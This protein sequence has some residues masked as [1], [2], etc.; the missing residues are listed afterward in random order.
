MSIYLLCM[1]LCV[2]IELG[3]RWI[4][5]GRPAFQLLSRPTGPLHSIEI[6]ELPNK[7]GEF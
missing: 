2:D 6:G 1:Q 7:G 5:P 3:D 4:G